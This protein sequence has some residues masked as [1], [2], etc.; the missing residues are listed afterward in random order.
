MF[1]VLTSVSIRGDR[2]NS[3]YYL[4]HSTL[5]EPLLPAEVKQELVATMQ[6]GVLQ[7]HVPTAARLMAQRDHDLFS[8]IDSLEYMA[9]LFKDASRST[10][11]L[12]AFTD[13]FNQVCDWIASEVSPLCSLGLS[14]PLSL[15]SVSPSWNTVNA[16]VFLQQSLSTV[17]HGHV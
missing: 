15:H 16:L 6:G 8:S 9:F 13:R 1:A 12:Q 11:N 5:I 10:A 7:I 3:R 14:L 4:K 2:P 17:T